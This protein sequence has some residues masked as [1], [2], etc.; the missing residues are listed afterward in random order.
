MPARLLLS[1]LSLT[2]SAAAAGGASFD[3]GTGK[4][5]PVVNKSKGSLNSVSKRL[6]QVRIDNDNERLLDRILSDHTKVRCCFCARS[7]IITRQP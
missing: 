5:P 1:D 6:E 2:V 4:A 7:P 3:V